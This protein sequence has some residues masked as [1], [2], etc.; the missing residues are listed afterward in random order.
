MNSTFGSTTGEP[1]KYLSVVSLCLLAVAA[2]T[3]NILSLVIIKKSKKILSRPSIHFTIN[4]LFVDLLQGIFVIPI[5]VAK[6]INIQNRSGDN[7]I[8]DSFRFSYMITYYMSIFCV[9]L[10]GLDRYIATTFIF[11]YKALVKV[12]YVK[13]IVIALWVYVVTL[14]SIPFYLP[15]VSPQLLSQDECFYRQNTVWTIAMLVINCF[16]PYILILY[17]YK[18]IIKHIQDTEKVPI[19][20]ASDVTQNVL[21]IPQMKDVQ[22]FNDINNIICGNQKKTDYTK[23][24]I[25]ISILLS[26]CYAFFWTPSIVYYILS[27]FCRDKCF[28]N[29]N[30]V[31]QTYLE[32]AI[33]F[34]AFLNSLS[35]PIIYCFTDKEFRLRFKSFKHKFIL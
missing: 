34:L 15:E 29:L 3:I 16:V 20:K 22:K 33:K 32:F 27:K 17:F 23:N 10:I 8:C 19:K 26:T 35:A 18:Y 9:L 21:A 30:P 12:K 1:F 28:L 13:I 5:Y 24:I 11:K 7:F 25:K 2:I 31:S 14:C 6:K 4:L